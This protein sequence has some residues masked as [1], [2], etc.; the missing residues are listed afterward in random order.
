MLTGPTMP[1]P[2]RQFTRLLMIM[3][4]IVCA[5]PRSWAE[6]QRVKFYV[7]PD[8]AQIQVEPGGQTESASHPFLVPLPVDPNVTVTFTVTAEG[9][10]PYKLEVR[11]GELKGQTRFPA[12][13]AY[14]LSKPGSSWWFLFGFLFV[15]VVGAGWFLRRKST[16][17]PLITPSKSDEI[18]ASGPIEPYIIE[19]PLAEGGMAVV[20]RGKSPKAPGETVAIKVIR[21]EL[22]GDVDARKRFLR[23][24]EIC[25]KLE[26]PNLVK[27]FDAGVAP[28]GEHYLT[29][30]LLEGQNLADY[31]EEDPELPLE[32]IA[33]LM[34]PLCS[35]LAHIHSLGLVHRD[36]KPSNIFLDNRSGLKLVDLGIA[37]G[38]DFEAI[39]RT[40]IAV[41]S[42]H[43]MAPEQA[44]G[45][46]RPENDQ[47]SVGVLLFELLT[48]DRP[49]ASG[50]PIEIITQHLTAPIPSL[51][52]D[53]PNASLLLE[54]VIHRLMAKKPEARFASISEA[55]LALED[56]LKNAA[57]ENDDTCGVLIPKE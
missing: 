47:Y 51:F 36:V 48:G 6:D 30:E 43:Y 17:D 38:L 22:L 44:K 33:S 2:I 8:Q 42:P 11:S 23:E 32:E 40:G 1:S 18:Q 9:Y 21:D 4:T 54:A 28:S 3:G 16:R 12:S 13:G 7:E 15:S 53:N 57:D 31:L 34:L 55:A 5:S 14:Q 52:T 27:V 41:G 49:F 19:G 10:K 50:D 39:T 24:I 25:A 20:Y 29:M 46:V 45:E 56:A 35:A 26:H 37:R